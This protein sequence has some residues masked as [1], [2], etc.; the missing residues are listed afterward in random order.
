MEKGN[1]NHTSHYTPGQISNGLE[2]YG[3]K[4][5]KKREKERR[6]QLLEKKMSEFQRVGKKCY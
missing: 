4:R 5:E 2:V 6:I 3:K 1:W